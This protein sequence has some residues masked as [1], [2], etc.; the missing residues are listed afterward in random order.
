MATSPTMGTER[1]PTLPPL[2]MTPR[3][4]GRWE[5]ISGDTDP[6]GRHYIRRASTPTPPVATSTMPQAAG[7]RAIPMSKCDRCSSAARPCCSTSS[8]S[9]ACGWTRPHR[10]TLTTAC[11]TTVV[12]AG[13][14]QAVHL[15]GRFNSDSHFDGGD[16]VGNQGAA[17]HAAAGTLG[18]V[19]PAN[20]F[21]ILERRP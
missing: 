8:T 17:L 15:A 2:P 12:Q 21:V 7:R 6:H 3:P 16:D 4:D 18:V 13:R 1:T 11:T 20:G 9:T 10:S 5:A 14:K 19:L